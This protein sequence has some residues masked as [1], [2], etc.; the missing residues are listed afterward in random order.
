MKRNAVDVEYSE[1]GES[2]L[3]ELR[4]TAHPSENFLTQPATPPTTLNEPHDRGPDMHTI[5]HTQSPSSQVI[6]S[7]DISQEV[8]TFTDST[9]DINNESQ[10]IDSKG[11]TPPP[12]QIP[13]QDKWVDSETPPVTVLNKNGEK[14][15]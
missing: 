10:V 15:I 9:L 13:A 8:S 3:D 4:N 5:P 14:N 12:E 6:D 11:D 7:K 1:S 2:L